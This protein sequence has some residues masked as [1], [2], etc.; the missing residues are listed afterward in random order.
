MKVAARI[1]AATAVVVALASVSYAV[2][3]LRSRRAERRVALERE[4]RAVATALRYDIEAAPSAFRAPSEAA[5]REL[6]RRAVGWKV[7]VL[8]SALGSTVTF[9]PEARR[10]SSRWA[11]SLGARN[12]EGAASM[13]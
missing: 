3:D 10:A 11:A 7:M 5:V 1:T 6:A 2:V 12:A 9:Q 13:S 4:A 8:P